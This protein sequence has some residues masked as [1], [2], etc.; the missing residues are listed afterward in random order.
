MK[1]IKDVVATAINYANDDTHGYDQDYRDSPDFDCSSLIRKILLDN[2]FPITFTW[3]GNMAEDLIQHGFVD[4]TDKVNLATGSGLLAGDILLYHNIV[5]NNGHT[6]LYVGNSQIV[7]AS[8]NEL[9]TVRG[10]KTG[11]QTG[12]EIAVVPYYNYPW[13]RVFRFIFDKEN[14][15][16]YYT[17]QP[18]DSLW[19]ISQ[20]FNTTIDELVKLNNIKDPNMIYTG[21]VLLIRKNSIEVENDTIKIVISGATI[22]KCT[23]NGNTITIE[24]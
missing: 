21:Q 12:K 11:D 15:N 23:K 19:A 6:A 4:V 10:G 3:T 22:K 7:Q 18:Y 14:D 24:V 13:Q 17:V 9:G 5:S 8:L 20:K 2:G 16:I 1:S